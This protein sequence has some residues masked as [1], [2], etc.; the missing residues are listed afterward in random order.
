MQ[1]DQDFPEKTPEQEN[2]MSKNEMNVAKRIER[3]RKKKERED[4]RRNAKTRR[5][6]DGTWSVKNRKTQLG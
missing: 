6:K 5:S 4:E 1:I 2:G 3:E